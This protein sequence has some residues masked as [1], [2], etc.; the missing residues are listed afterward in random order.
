MSRNFIDLHMHSTASDGL[1]QPEEVMQKARAKGV[2]LI[3]LTDHDTMRGVQRAGAEA[4][5]L[6]MTLIPG[7]EISTRTHGKNCHL[8]AYFKMDG[9]QV[10]EMTR[11]CKLNNVILRHLLISHPKRLF[12]LMTEA[13]AKHAEESEAEP[14]AAT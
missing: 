13:L 4:Q 3:S 10:P 12:D 5:K 11:L 7:V 1:F 2:G 9:S 8:L 14:A 6:G